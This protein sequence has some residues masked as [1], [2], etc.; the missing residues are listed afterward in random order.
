MSFSDFHIHTVFS[1]GKNTPEE[2]IESAIKR[3]IKQLGFSDHSYTFFD[4]SYCMKKESRNDYIITINSLKSAYSEKINIYCGIEQDFYSTE[5]TDMYDYVIGSVHYVRIG[6]DYIPVDESA[7]DFKNA[8]LKYFG[9]DFITFAEEYF[10]TVSCVIE[11]TNADIIGHFDLISKFNAQGLFDEKDSR[12]ISAWKKAVDNLLKYEKP[13]EINTGAISRG[14]KAFPYPSKTI[15]DYIK[16]NGGKFIL[17]SDAHSLKNI[18]FEFEK[19]SYL[20]K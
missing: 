4:K 9:G 15:I 12:Y 3:G 11:K 13:F 19:W 7:E 1:D 17:S 18:G 5:Q 8:V 10:K 2:M 20:I 14:Y 16:Q 6:D